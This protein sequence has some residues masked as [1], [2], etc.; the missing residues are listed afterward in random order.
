MNQ[1]LEYEMDAEDDRRESSPA[2]SCP[3][4][5]ISYQQRCDRCGE[6]S[7]WCECGWERDIRCDC[8][9]ED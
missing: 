7:T 3:R 8:E 5:G 6:K 1:Y 9:E 2:L 4:C